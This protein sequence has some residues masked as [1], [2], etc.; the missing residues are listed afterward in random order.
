[1]LQMDAGDTAWPA[2]PEHLTSR[3]TCMRD[4]MRWPVTPHDD[5]VLACRCWGYCEQRERALRAGIARRC[6]ASAGCR[7][8]RSGE[9]L[10]G[11]SM[12]AAKC[13]RSPEGERERSC[14]EE[15]HKQDGKGAPHLS[16]CYMTSEI[17]CDSGKMLISGI[18]DASEFQFAD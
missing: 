16:S 8:W 5:E 9:R 2:G 15:Q 1:M 10:D 6:S 3:A 7:P 11:G 12:R 18:I 4:G 14:S 17:T 13:R